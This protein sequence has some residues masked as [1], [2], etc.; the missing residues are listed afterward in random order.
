MHTSAIIV[1]AVIIIAVIVIIII[2]YDK[3]IIITMCT[4]GLLQLRG[5]WSRSPCCRC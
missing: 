2:V 1:L 5:W 4:A 3:I